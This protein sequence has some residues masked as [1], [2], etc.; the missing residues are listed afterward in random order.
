MVGIAAAKG[1]RLRRRIALEPRDEGALNGRDIA[2]SHCVAGRVDCR[3]R[4]GCCRTCARSRNGSGWLLRSA[5]LSP[6]QGFDGNLRLLPAVLLR[7]HLPQIGDIGG[8]F[9]GRQI[10]AAIPSASDKRPCRPTTR[11]RFLRTRGSTRG[12]PAARRSVAS[13]RTR[14]LEARRK[15]RDWTEPKARPARS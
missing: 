10:R 9:I 3:V 13:A 8:G 6:D 2:A 7:Q 15:G 1:M 12:C 14:S 5:S 4:I 11:A